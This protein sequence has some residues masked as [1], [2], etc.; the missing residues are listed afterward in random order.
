[1]LESAQS[2]HYRQSITEAVPSCDKWRTF[3]KLLGNSSSSPLPA[4]SSKQELSDQFNSFFTDKIK[5]IR[6]GLAENPVEYP[7]HLRSARA[8]FTGTPMEE[9]NLY[10]KMK[11]VKSSAPRRVLHADSTLCQH[12]CLRSACLLCSPSPRSSTTSLKSSEFC[13]SLKRSYIAQEG[14]PRS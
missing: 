9:S 8:P 10:L 4:H 11:W 1:M 5:T 2:L 12:G 14:L 6:V 7:D 3:N 13:S